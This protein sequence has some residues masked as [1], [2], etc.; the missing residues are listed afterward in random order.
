MKFVRPAVQGTGESVLVLNSWETLHESS[1]MLLQTAVEIKGTE[2]QTV[3]FLTAH[4]NL[5]LLAI[6]HTRIMKD[7]IYFWWIQCPSPRVSYAT[8]LV[9]LPI[10]RQLEPLGCKWRDD[11]TN[12]LEMVRMRIASAQIWH[13]MIFRI[14]RHDGQSCQCSNCGIFTC[15]LARKEHTKRLNWEKVDIENLVD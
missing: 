2:A 7:L 3:G 1:G 10:L 14:V 6:V 13:L 9:C 15:C 11:R 8:S 4:Y 12:S 5:S